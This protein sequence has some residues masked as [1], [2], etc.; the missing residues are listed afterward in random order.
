[1]DEKNKSILLKPWIY[2]IKEPTG[3]YKEQLN[4]RNK[5]LVSLELE[6]VHGYRSFDCKNNAKYL[7]SGQVVYNCA[8][9]GIVLSTNNPS[10]L[11]NQRF[12]NQHTN[13]ISSLSIH[14]DGTV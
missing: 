13:D 5:P 9:L 6:F 8:A 11:P 4:S 2:S 14:P 10:H 1:M 3:F 7:K 12:F